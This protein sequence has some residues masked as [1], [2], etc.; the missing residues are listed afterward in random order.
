M[1]MPHLLFGVV[2]FRIFIVTSRM[3]KFSLEYGE[4][5]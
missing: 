5:V 3:I 2:L 1:D 4:N